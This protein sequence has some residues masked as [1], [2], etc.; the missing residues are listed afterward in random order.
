[1]LCYQY[2]TV[3]DLTSPV[4]IILRVASWVITTIL[5]LT[6]YWCDILMLQCCSLVQDAL[7]L[8]CM[9]CSQDAR[10][11]RR[12]KNKEHCDVIIE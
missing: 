8:V 9:K 10:P 2:R 3:A 6:L 11:R 7:A 5:L 1:M 4:Y 12:G